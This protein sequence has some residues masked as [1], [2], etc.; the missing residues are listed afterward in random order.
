[1]FLKGELGKWLYM[2][3]VIG[4]SQSKRCAGLAHIL[5]TAGATYHKVYHITCAAVKGSVNYVVE[6]RIRALCR[7]FRCHVMKDL[8]IFSRE[9][10]TDSAFSVSCLRPISMASQTLRECL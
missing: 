10:A 3:S 6:I 2:C 5:L 8:A 9:W 4:K 7:G 1:M